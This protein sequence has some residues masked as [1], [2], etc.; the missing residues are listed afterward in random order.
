MKVFRKDMSL[1]LVTDRSWL[2][3][4][5]LPDVVEEAIRGNVSFVQI[6]EKNINYQEFKK[7]ALELKVIT[8][9][10]HI[11]FVINDNIEL[12]IDIDADGVHLGQD[13]METSKARKLLGNNKILGISVNTVEQAVLAEKEGADYLGIGSIFNT[14]TK[15]D[16]KVINM[17][18]IK[19]IVDS[20]S[21]PTVGI[22]GIN[23]DNIHLLENSKL[24]GIA[25][26]SAILKE[27][28]IELSAKN[29]SRLVKE[30]LYDDKDI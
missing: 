25:V 13:D 10:Y 11:P 1:Y 16:A 23:K 30:N 17:D 4:R 21:I 3:N 27:K 15:L 28:D 6:R 22:G 14:G 26:V 20:V 18:I 5:N 7:L 9:K 2:G 12:A 29:L 8:D 19:N 24:D